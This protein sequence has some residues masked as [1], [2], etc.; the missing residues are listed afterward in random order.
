MPG[1]GPHTKRSREHKKTVACSNAARLPRCDDQAQ[2]GECSANQT[3]GYGQHLHQARLRQ[4]IVVQQ[5]RHEM[6]CNRKDT[7]AGRDQRDREPGNRVA[8]C[9]VD[10]LAII[11]DACERR[12]ERTIDR[13]GQLRHRQ[14]RQLVADVVQTE[15][16]RSLHAADDKIRAALLEEY[17]HVADQHPAR[18]GHQFAHVHKRKPRAKR[19]HVVADDGRHETRAERADHQCPV[20]AQQNAEWHRDQHRSQLFAQQEHE[21]HGGT[22]FLAKRDH[23][24]I[25]QAGEG[26]AEAERHHDQNTPACRRT[27]RR[28]APPTHHSRNQQT[29]HQVAGPG[30]VI[31]LLGRL[32]ILDQRDVEPRTPTAFGHRDE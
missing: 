13:R 24:D 31:V 7:G 16:T 20:A 28:H 4:A 25:F 30:G 6:R 18:E 29:Q 12:N 19:V 21:I 17:H 23:A 8:E 10:S 1:A 3:A 11:L 22:A 2:I 26:R 32:L 9:C 27:P 14:L 5:H 15:R